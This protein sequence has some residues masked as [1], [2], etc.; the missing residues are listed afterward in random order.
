VS[1]LA[2]SI[3]GSIGF[4]N[5]SL[6]QSRKYESHTWGEKLSALADILIGNIDLTC[7]LSCT[8][9]VNVVLIVFIG[10]LCHQCSKNLTSLEM[11]KKKHWQK[12]YPGE[13]FVNMYDKGFW[14]DWFCGHLLQNSI[15]L[16]FL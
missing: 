10:M 15:H 2:I 6:K 14:G 3:V 16:I 8:I 1:C 5:H 11:S 12:Q 7:S 4:L 13:V 9:G